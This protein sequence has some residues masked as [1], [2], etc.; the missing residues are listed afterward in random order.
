MLPC[1]KNLQ[2]DE[3]NGIS[4]ELNG[5]Y[6]NNQFVHKLDATM[7]NFLKKVL[8]LAFHENWMLPCGISLK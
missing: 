1:G 2:N 4:Q 7:W 8:S 5:K 3:L 6:Y